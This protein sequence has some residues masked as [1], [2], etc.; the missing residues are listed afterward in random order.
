MTNIKETLITAWSPWT[1]AYVKNYLKIEASVTVDDALVQ[2]R[3]DAALGY[4]Q[5]YT[6]R[7][8]GKWSVE[9]YWDGFRSEFVLS[10]GVV[11]E[12]DDFEYWDGTNWLLVDPTLYNFH[13]LVSSGR[14]GFTGAIPVGYRGGLGSVR[15]RYKV[16][17]IDGSDVPKPVIEMALALIGQW[18]ENKSDQDITDLRYV[19]TILRNYV[20]NR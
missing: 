15:V 1:L 6:F 9:E 19:N 4:V 12:F 14:L 18:F 2:S 10:V 16:G 7:R 8:L 17:T 11:S 5:R 13:A 3:M 20:I